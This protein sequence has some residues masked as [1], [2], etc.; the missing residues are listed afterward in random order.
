MTMVGGANRA[1]WTDVEF[2]A[3]DFRSALERADKLINDG[4]EGSVESKAALGAAWV[5]L[6][7]RVAGAGGPR[8]NSS[9]AAAASTPFGAVAAPHCSKA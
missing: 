4:T 2:W 8:R 9:G 6:S 1:A 3:L 5:A 7:A